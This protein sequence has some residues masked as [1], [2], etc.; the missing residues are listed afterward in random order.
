MI[1]HPPSS[2]E[3]TSSSLRSQKD[4][5]EKMHA[6]IVEDLKVLDGVSAREKAIADWNEKLQ[7]KEKELEDL[8]SVYIKDVQ[9]LQRRY[10]ELGEQIRQHAEAQRI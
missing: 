4:E 10:T 2:Q 5:L 7:Q 3:I 9:I 8:R 1:I 6:K